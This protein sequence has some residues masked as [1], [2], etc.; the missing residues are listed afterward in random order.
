MNQLDVGLVL[1]LKKGYFTK[2]N[3]KGVIFLLL[4]FFFTYIRRHVIGNPNFSHPDGFINAIPP[5]DRFIYLDVLCSF[6]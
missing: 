2:N 1:F 4:S 3:R 5:M 6:T